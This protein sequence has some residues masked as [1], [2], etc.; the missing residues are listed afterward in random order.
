M[1]ISGYLL[2]KP[3]TPNEREFYFSFLER[4]EKPWYKS[5][6]RDNYYIRQLEI[7]YGLFYDNGPGREF[8]LPNEHYAPDCKCHECEE[9]RAWQAELETKIRQALRDNPEQAKE[10]HDEFKRGIIF[11]LRELAIK[12]WFSGYIDNPFEN[13]R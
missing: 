2:D 7:K 8:K 13:F 11:S 1:R 5:T 10:V 12:H 4:I 6:Y 9:H 3:L